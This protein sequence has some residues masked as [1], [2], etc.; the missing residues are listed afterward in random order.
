MQFKS[1]AHFL[2][3]V[4]AYF[5]I[6]V[7]MQYFKN[8]SPFPSVMYIAKTFPTLLTVFYFYSVFYHKDSLCFIFMF[9]FTMSLFQTKSITFIF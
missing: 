1:F 6:N 7:F 2:V 8:I 4:S 5:L 3:E 9:T